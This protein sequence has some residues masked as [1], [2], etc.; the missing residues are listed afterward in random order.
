MEFLKESLVRCLV[1][2]LLKVK[3]D[4]G[5]MKDIIIRTKR[6]WTLEQHQ[7]KKD[8]ADV[9]AASGGE[10]EVTRSGQG[11]A[12]GDGQGRQ[13]ASSVLTPA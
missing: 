11:R 12:G 10:M 3:N 4:Y 1:E 2:S 5:G 9:R 13:G 8:A 6:W 7:M